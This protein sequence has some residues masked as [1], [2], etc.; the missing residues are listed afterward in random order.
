[1]R[2]IE[3]RRE[4]G[5]TGRSHQ[6]S[7]SSCGCSSWSWRVPKVLCARWYGCEHGGCWLTDWRV[8][9]SRVS[10]RRCCLDRFLCLGG[11]SLLLNLLA[12]SL[13]TPVLEPDLHLSLGKLEESSELFPFMSREVFL[14]SKPSLQFV[15]L[16]M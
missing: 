9:R 2:V 5:E 10:R 12:L 7:G 1:M 16:S 4:C 14:H 6:G 11:E 8:K 15:H 13:V 3:R